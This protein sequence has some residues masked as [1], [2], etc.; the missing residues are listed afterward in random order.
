[1]KMYLVLA[2]ILISQNISA[3]VIKNNLAKL[4]VN[5]LY[6]IF[7]TDGHIFIEK[8]EETGV[9][10]SIG[11]H[12]DKMRGVD[13]SYTTKKVDMQTFYQEGLTFVTPTRKIKVL[14]IR[15]KNVFDNKGGSIELVMRDD[16]SNEHVFPFRIVE[17]GN[18]QIYFTGKE[19]EE[20]VNDIYVDTNFSGELKEFAINGDGVF[21]P[22]VSRKSLAVTHFQ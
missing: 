2:I 3:K 5:I 19:R 14:I 21:D 13:A 20:H 1:M 22:S 8:D 16:R 15:P 11:Y 7:N 4:E 17:E 10:I 18:F 12:L 6:P 9:I